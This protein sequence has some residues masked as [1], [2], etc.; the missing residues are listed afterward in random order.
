MADPIS[1]LAKL[2]IVKLSADLEVQLAAV[3]GGGPC[4]EILRRLQDRAAESLAGLAVCDTEDPR[5]IRLLQN[6]VKR[7]D[8]WLHAMKDIIAEGKFYDRELTEDD[9]NDLLDLITEGADDR[10]AAIYGLVDDVP[11]DA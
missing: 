6:E 9:R 7:Y 4:V 5:A 3:Q 8:E 1:R 11:Q 2:R 10:E